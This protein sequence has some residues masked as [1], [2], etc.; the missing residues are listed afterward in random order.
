LID[1]I[2]VRKA[3]PKRAMVIFD[4][5]FGNTEKIARWFESGLQEADI[6]TLCISAKTVS[7]EALKEYDLICVGAP[8]EWHTSSKPMKELLKKLENVDFSGKY[9]FAFDTRL[10]R[11]FS[12][13][14]AKFIEKRLKHLGLEIIAQSESATVFLEHGQVGDAW[15]KEGEEKR[16]ERIGRQVGADLLARAGEIPA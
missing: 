6:E 15:L 13:S 10:D 3:G 7:V 1:Q 8:T 12:G 11:L 4:T 2:V 14:A 5:R 16:F 9:G